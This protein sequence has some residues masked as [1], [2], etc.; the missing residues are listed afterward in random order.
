VGTGRTIITESVNWRAKGAI[1]AFRER[2]EGMDPKSLVLPIALFIVFIGIAIG[3]VN[4]QQRV[5]NENPPKLEVTQPTN[6]STTQD[7][8]IVVEGNTTKD[9]KVKVNGQDVTVSTNGN[10][11]AEVPLN[12]GDNSIGV[13]AENGA[14]KKSEVT[15]K[16]TRA[17]ATPQNVTEGNA[18]ATQPTAG[19][20][21]LSSSGPEDYLFPLGLFAGVL[22]LW[23]KSKKSF[24]LA[25]QS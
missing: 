1:M 9:S 7:S 22:M 15:L 24:N 25:I 20:G 18:P 21:K 3:I 8:Q 11:A 19:N 12:D 5:K 13:V 17:G 4:Y 14:G 16:V 2:F 6:E 10:F 23:Y